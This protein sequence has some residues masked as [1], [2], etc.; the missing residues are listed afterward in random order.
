[1]WLALSALGMIA[2]ENLSRRVKTLENVLL[3]LKK[4]ELEVKQFSRPFSEIAKKLSGCEKGNG[5]ASECLRFL[6]EG[7]KFPAA[8]EKGT[9]GCRLPFKKEERKMLSQLGNDL[10]SCDRDGCFQVLGVYFERFKL[11]LD[12]AK[13]SKSRYS[14]LFL[15]SGVFVGGMIF[16][17]IA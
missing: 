16:I 6:N 17:S 13:A 14:K 12:E 11:F 8:W 15:F 7:E 9:Q 10:C 3:L 1:M 4:T 5:L 2:A